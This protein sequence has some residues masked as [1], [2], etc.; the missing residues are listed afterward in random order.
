M[1]SASFCFFF[2]H[3]SS[4]LRFASSS[5]C[6]FLVQLL[7]FV[8][9][10]LPPPLSSFL[11]QLFSLPQPRLFWPLLLSFSLPHFLPFSFPV[12]LSFWHQLQPFSFLQQPFSLLLIELLFQ[13][14][15]FV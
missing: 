6:F 8:S 7:L 12:L 2:A 15:P 1:A 4:F 9:F 10:L 5:A 14:Q 13:L 3:C 11:L